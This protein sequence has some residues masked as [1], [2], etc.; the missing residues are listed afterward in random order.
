MLPFTM[1]L[2]IYMYVS[3]LLERQAQK[4]HK[5]KKSKIP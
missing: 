5:K 3:I 4:N 1:N 2:K